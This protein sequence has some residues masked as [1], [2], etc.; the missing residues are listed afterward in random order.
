MLVDTR[1]AHVWSYAIASGSSS[2]SIKTGRLVDV[3][4][5]CSFKTSTT[6]STTRVFWLGIDWGKQEGGVIVDLKD[7]GTSCDSWVEFGFCLLL[8]EGSVSIIATDRIRWVVLLTLL[9]LILCCSH[10]KWNGLHNKNI[11]ISSC[12][13]CSH[14]KWNGLH[15]QIIDQ[16]R[17]IINWYI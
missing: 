14:R 13:V 8:G 3:D 5:D 10:R 4:E 15:N 1:S 2:S 12:V 16:L 7:L 6:T 9:L 11:Y 17:T